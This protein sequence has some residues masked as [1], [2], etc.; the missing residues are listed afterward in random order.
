MSL[1]KLPEPKA[2]E[3]PG[4]V[5]WDAPSD[6]LARWAEQ[7]QAAEADDP[8]TISIYD[9][10]GE[11]IFGDGVTAKRIAAALRRIG[12]SPVSVSINSP[13]GDFFEGLAIYNLLREHPAAVNVNVQ[14]LAAS[15]ASVIAMAGDDIAMGQGSFMMIHNVW[16]LAI[17][18]RHDMRE[19]A[20]ML[21]PF[22]RSLMEI[23]AARTGLKSDDVGGL[24]DA[25]TWLNASDAV[26]RGF[27]D[28]KTEQASGARNDAPPHVAAKRRMDAI[29]A[30]A[31]MARAE[32]SRLMREVAG[33]H[34]AA[35]DG[36]HDAA[37]I[38]AGLDRIK[39]TLKV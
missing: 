10:I 19:A 27:A 20:D 5:K 18:N 25:E 39:E 26:E 22:D 1:R 32:R 3:R 38:S 13:G 16:V 37:E 24:L 14:G 2:L 33:T 9:P 34:D 35:P 8:N 21:E 30:E 15:A 4:A 31:G 36:T 11:D 23:Y 17:G 12:E 29:L 28:R 6:A 7:P